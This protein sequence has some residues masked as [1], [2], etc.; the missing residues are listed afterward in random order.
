MTFFTVMAAALG[1]WIFG[2]IW[3]T[4]MGKT[5]MIEVGLTD[6][7]IDRK[8]PIPYIASFLCMVL[9]AGMMRHIFASANVATLIE[10]LVSGL[11]LGL[12]IAVPWLST[13]YF[14]AQ[15]SRRLLVIDGIHAAGGS[16]V[17]GGLLVMV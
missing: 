14:F 8:N 5:W 4:I 15:R 7:T 12:F 16:M 10:G 2:A 9:V 6:A 13:N 3:Y 11:G 1:A 17:M